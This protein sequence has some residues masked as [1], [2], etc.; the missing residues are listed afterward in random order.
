MVGPLRTN[1]LLTAEMSMDIFANVED[2]LVASRNLAEGLEKK[3]QEDHYMVQLLGRVLL[4]RIGDLQV[5]VGYSSNLSRAS[6]KLADY[7]KENPAFQAFLTERQWTI[8]KL[9]GF[10]VKPIQRVLK[11]DLQVRPS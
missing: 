4:D 10:L 7:A 8:M 9:D 2:L 5:C 6:R 1:G 3:V 11:L